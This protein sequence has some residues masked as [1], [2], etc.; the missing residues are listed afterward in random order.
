MRD[1]ILKAIAGKCITDQAAFEAV[2]LVMEIVEAQN[3]EAKEALDIAV[4]DVNRLEGE[5]E[6]LRERVSISIRTNKSH[7]VK[8]KKLEGEVKEFRE[9]VDHNLNCILR[10]HPK[11]LNECT[12]GLDK[13][14]EK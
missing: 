8:N 12:C 6:V 10:K 11:A 4:N 7:Y 2:D 13:L 1:K 9:Y 3:K 5:N 14:L